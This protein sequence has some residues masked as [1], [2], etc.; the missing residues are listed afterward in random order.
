MIRSLDL[1]I[2]AL[3]QQGLN[4]PYAIQLQAGLS[5]GSTLPAFRRLLET[6]LVKEE[7]QEQG[8]RRRREFTLTAAGKKKLQ[9]AK[10]NLEEISAN[11]VG[12]LEATL[13]FACLASFWGDR[14]EASRI[15]LRAA[16]EFE[17][18]S[19]NSQRIGRRRVESHSE[20]A[21]IYRGL[22]FLSEADRQ[23]GI[24]KRLRALASEFESTSPKKRLA[25]ETS[26]SERR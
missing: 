22:L 6:E 8:G 9:N 3:I 24:A 25:V 1:F 13:R 21:S 7:E 26:T 20:L 23:K 14:R 11:A 4:V 19:E 17:D 5:V 15:L 2:L 12:D 16:G 10:T 18:R